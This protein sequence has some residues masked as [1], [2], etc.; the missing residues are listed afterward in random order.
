[1]RFLFAIP[2]RPHPGSSQASMRGKVRKLG[3]FWQHSP[4]CRTSLPLFGPSLPTPSPG[5]ISS[6]CRVLSA[7]D[8]LKVSRLKDTGRKFE[9]L[10]MHYSLQDD[11]RIS[12]SVCDRSCKRPWTAS[13]RCPALG[14][15]RDGRTSAL[16]LVVMNCVLTSLVSNL[17]PRNSLER[18][19]SQRLE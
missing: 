2:Q 17:I 15:T 9:A 18:T 13:V 14:R 11:G 16:R 7:Y 5:E 12:F 8:D 4:T 6:F 1:M 10:N 3:L 19:R